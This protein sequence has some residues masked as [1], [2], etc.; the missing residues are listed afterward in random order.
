[1]I[2]RLMNPAPLQYQGGGNQN[3]VTEFSQKLSLLE[4]VVPR[5]YDKI[6]IYNLIERCIVTL[7]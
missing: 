1:M 7:R 4:K 2:T 6:I 5:Y 3:V